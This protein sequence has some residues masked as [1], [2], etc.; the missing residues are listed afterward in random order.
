MKHFDDPARVEVRKDILP[1]YSGFFILGD[2][3]FG[4]VGSLLCLKDPEAQRYYVVQDSALGKM[5]EVLTKAWGPPPA[6][7]LSR[8]QWQEVVAALESTK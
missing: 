8:E 7:D 1:A 2:V 4:W 6:H 5:S 3:Q